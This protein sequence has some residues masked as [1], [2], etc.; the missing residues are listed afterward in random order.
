MREAITAKTSQI[1]ELQKLLT[2]FFSKKISANFQILM[3]KILMKLLVSNN[4]F[5]QI[6]WIN[7]EK[8]FISQR[9]HED[10]IEIW[11]SFEGEIFTYDNSLSSRYRGGIQDSSKIFFLISQRKHM[12]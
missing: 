6:F 11:V 3:F 5:A 9:N 8:F 2:C 12:L 7:L 1:F 10:D 4:S